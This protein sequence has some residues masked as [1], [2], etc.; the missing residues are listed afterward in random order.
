MEENSLHAPEPQSFS[1][2]QKHLW[3]W[4]SYT[5]GYGILSSISCVY[6]DEDER[7]TC[8]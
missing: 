7:S 2:I 1:S 5:P 3:M 4:H 8:L 6:G